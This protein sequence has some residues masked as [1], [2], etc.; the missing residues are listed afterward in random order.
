MFKKLYSSLKSSFQIPQTRKIQEKIDSLKKIDNE[1]TANELCKLLRMYSK[2]SVSIPVDVRNCFLQNT[3]FENICLKR[4]CFWNSNLTSSTFKKAQLPDAD[5]WQA[6]LNNANF[7]NA[8]LT[9]SIFSHTNLTHTNFSG[10][11]L[12]NAR[13]D[14]ARL[15]G[16]DFS[17]A[18]LK[19][20][21]VELIQ[22]KKV[23]SLKN[24]IMPDGTVFSK[25]W[26]KAIKNV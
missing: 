22:F 16:T 21:K 23:K 20:A 10:A 6:N 12:K 7:S 3:N 18:N 2:L 8:V 17:D 4:V 14:E 5:F 15:E 19:W 24:A 11:V 9:N 13:F 26:E 25:E 1:K